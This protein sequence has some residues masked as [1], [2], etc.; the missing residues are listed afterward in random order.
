MPIVWDAS[1]R[2]GHHIIDSQ[3]EELISLISELSAVADGNAEVVGDVLRRLGA[4]VIF[5]FSTE[6]SLFQ[7]VIAPD[8]LLEHQ[9]QHRDF[10]QCLSDFS[11]QF[12]QIG[13]AVVPNLLAW[14]TEWLKMH[15]Q[16][17]DR[18]LVAV[19]CERNRTQWPSGSR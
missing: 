15:I 19:L 3:H 16:V 1:M 18:R 6:E 9:Q 4:Y 11:S 7:G 12:A 5:H 8:I 14:L 17:S 13:T 10:S 2:V